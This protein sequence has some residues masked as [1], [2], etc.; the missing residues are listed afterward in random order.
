MVDLLVMKGEAEQLEIRAD[1][2]DDYAAD[3]LIELL[4]HRQDSEGLLRRTN[5]GD[6]M[7]R[8][9]LVDILARNAAVDQ[10]ATWPTAETARRA[11]GAA[12]SGIASTRG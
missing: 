10:L 4:V 12:S 3:R 1:H 5:K 7:A 11:A 9:A 8:A 2:G 6:R